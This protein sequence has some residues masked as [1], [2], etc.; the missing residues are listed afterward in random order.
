MSIIKNF[1]TIL[2]LNL[3]G[4]LAHFRKFYTN[5][6]S[7]TYTIPPRTAICGLMASILMQPRDSYYDL[8]K[9][10]NLGVGI[11]IPAESVFRRQFFTMNYVGNEKVINDV[12]GHKQCRLELLMPAPGN[13]LNWT[14]YLA[15]KQGSDDLLD[16]LE[17]RIR[18][19]N[20]GFD[21]YL[22][23]RQF[24]AEIELLRKFSKEDISVFDKS[25]YLDSVISKDQIVTL[26]TANFHLNIERMPLEQILETK[27]KSSYRR[28]VRSADVVIEATG[29]RLF[30]EFNNLIELNNEAKTRIALL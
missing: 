17:D 23:Q 11:S 5:A 15:T 12:S 18:N 21:V 27:G 26:D 16:S 1:D 22:G 6:S 28:S 9:S 8:L 14:L 3:S 24:R 25:D 2:E 30:G 7:L 13:K 19:Q 4:E 29:K 10:E 20:L